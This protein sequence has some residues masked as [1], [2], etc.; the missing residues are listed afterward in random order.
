MTPVVMDYRTDNYEWKNDSI[1]GWDEHRTFELKVANYRSMP[2]K[3]EIRR[4][5][6]VTTWEIENRDDWNNYSKVDADTV[7]YMLDLSPN[8]QKIITYDVT[9][10]MGSRGSK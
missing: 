7:Q 2:V 3:V 4:N 8:G 9:W 6:P 5:F 1:T 10:H